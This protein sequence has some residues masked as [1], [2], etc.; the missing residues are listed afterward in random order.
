[1]CARR[2]GMTAGDRYGFV[3]LTKTTRVVRDGVRYDIRR[4]ATAKVVRAESEKTSLCGLVNEFLCSLRRAKRRSRLFPA[5]NVLRGPRVEYA[6]S[7]QPIKY[8]VSAKEMSNP[9]S[10]SLTTGASAPSQTSRHVGGNDAYA[11]PP[12]V[13]ILAAASSAATVGLTV[14]RTTHRTLPR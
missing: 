1:M 14:L 11:N 5:Q 12:V 3:V 2:L 13:W 4:K 6:M 10:F 7:C 8:D 9:L